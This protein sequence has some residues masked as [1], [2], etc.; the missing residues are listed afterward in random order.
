MS[1]PPKAKSI[2]IEFPVFDPALVEVLTEPMSKPRSATSQHGGRIRNVTQHAKLPPR[3]APTHRSLGCLIGSAKAVLDYY[4]P[5]VEELATDAQERDLF[6]KLE[7]ALA[8]YLR[9]AAARGAAPTRPAKDR[10]GLHLMQ[11]PPVVQPERMYLP[12]TLP[13]YED[14]TISG[15]FIEEL[16]T[17]M[18][19]E[20]F[21]QCMAY[22]A[23]AKTPLAK[24]P[25]TGQADRVALAWDIELFFEQTELPNA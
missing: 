20:R 1:D 3:K 6:R 14:G 2:L 12:F 19:D 21:A 4:G 13:L 25:A 7:G 16:R 17:V 10:K 15:Y 8:P 24:N 11:K 18:T 9:I 22:L 5:V 23:G